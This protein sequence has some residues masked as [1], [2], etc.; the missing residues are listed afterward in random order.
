MKAAVAIS[1]NGEERA[2][3]EGSLRS[4]TTEQRWARRARI[5]LAAAGNK[6]LVNIA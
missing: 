4:G 5:V 6:P 2:S 3:L 1:L